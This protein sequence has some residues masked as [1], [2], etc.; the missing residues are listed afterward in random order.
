MLMSLHICTGSDELSLFS[1]VI[2]IK[3]NANAHL[4]NVSIHRQITLKLVKFRSCG[5]LEKQVGS[6]SEIDAFTCLVKTKNQITREQQIR[7]LIITI[8]CNDMRIN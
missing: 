7:L 1:N 6:N 2:N 3:I 4:M 5:K 8:V